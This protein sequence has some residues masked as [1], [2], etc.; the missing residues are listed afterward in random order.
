MS[1]AITEFEGD[2]KGAR[3]ASSRPIAKP[4]KVS[5]SAPETPNGIRSPLKTPTHPM[6]SPDD[7]YNDDGAPRRPNHGRSLSNSSMEE[8]DHAGGD[9]GNDAKENSRKRGS[10]DVPEYPRRRATIAVCFL[11]PRPAATPLADSHYSVKSVEGASH[12]ATARNPVASCA[13]SSMPI[14]YIESQA[15]SSTPAISSYWKG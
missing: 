4:K 6:R 9:N 12:G 11:L 14:A 2:P 10:T 1:A 15:S 13:R 3:P 5:I 7:S 8:E